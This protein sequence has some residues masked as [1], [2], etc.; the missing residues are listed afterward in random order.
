[1]NAP[2]REWVEKAEG[3]YVTALR[4]R[5]ARKNPNHDAVCFHAQQCV[6]KYLKG[7]L[8]AEDVAFTKTHDLVVLLQFAQPSIRSGWRGKTTPNCCPVLPS[9]FA[10]RAKAPHRRMRSPPHAS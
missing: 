2:I 7:V 5:R 9:S 6:E 4:E 3:D 10:I 1:L 8:Q